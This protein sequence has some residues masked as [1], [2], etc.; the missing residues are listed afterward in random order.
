MAGEISASAL[1]L[2]GKLGKLPQASF[3]GYTHMKARPLDELRQKIERVG[4]FTRTTL[5]RGARV[6]KERFIRERLSAVA[7][8]TEKLPLSAGLR[9]RSGKLLKS[10]RTT[11]TAPAMD[12]QKLSA[13][14]GGPAAFYAIVHERSGRL[15]FARVFGEERARTMD[16]IARGVRRILQSKGVTGAV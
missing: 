3:H 5:Q 1:A 13:K 16:I 2:L 9:Q 14:I 6:F 10:L 15:Q 12:R 8:Y 11:V 7:P 4:Y